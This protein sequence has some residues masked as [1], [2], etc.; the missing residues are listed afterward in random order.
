MVRMKMEMRMKSLATPLDVSMCW[1]LLVAGQMRES[2]KL[3]GSVLPLHCAQ[4]TCVR[5]SGHGTSWLPPGERGGDAIPHGPGGSGFVTA[6]E[7][8]E[9]HWSLFGIFLV[10][11]SVGGR[12]W[13][14]CWGI[15]RQMPSEISIS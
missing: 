13:D 10:R 12:L 9:C 14:I 5:I 2:T 1:C 6:P 11:S 3:P 4:T 15:A 7:E 8:D